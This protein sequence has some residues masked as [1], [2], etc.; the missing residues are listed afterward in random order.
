[1]SPDQTPRAPRH[2]AL[3][4]TLVVLLMCAA[5][6]GA[7]ARTAPTPVRLA[8]TADSMA[9]VATLTGMFDALR[10]KDGA[11]V[12]SYL[13]PEARFTLLRPTPGAG[14]AVRVVVMTGEQFAAATTGPGATGVDEP[15]RN[16]TVTV[17]G[18][19]ATAWAEYQVRANGA[20]SH[21]G[22]DA[23]HL[24]RQGDAWKV[25]NISD[26]FRRDGC[27]AMWTP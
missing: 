7:P 2:T 20:V 21:C 12:R 22:Y 23:I 25:L 17:D 5:C 11:A 26:S 14:D 15:I 19:L 24:V 18:P 8:S 13:L 27:G 9:V 16:I 6:G 10:V 1:M 3:P 4:A